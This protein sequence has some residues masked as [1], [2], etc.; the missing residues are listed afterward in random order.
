M[1]FPRL[2]IDAFKVS[3][4][5]RIINDRCTG[6]GISV[7]G[8]TKGVLAHP[9]VTAALM[10]AGIK[11][12]GDSR[13][14][15]VK[16]LFHYTGDPGNIMMLRSPMHDEVE[17][18]INMC[19]TSLN[20]QS[21]TVDMLS[22]ACRKYGKDH[23]IIIMV[24]I[25]DEREGLLPEE[26]YG[27]C[28]YIMG[29]SK[30]IHIKGIGTNARCITSRGP[31]RKSI[32]ILVSLKE[33]LEDRLGL[34]LEIL[35]GG[36]SSIWDMIISGELPP[37]INQVR[38]GEAIF[39]GH[40]TAGYK[41]IEGTFQDCFTLEAEII[42]VKNRDN[43]PYRLVLALG[44]QDVLLKDLRL[45]ERG[46]EAVSQSSDHT[47]LDIIS[48]KGDMEQEKDFSNFRA[49]GIISFNLNYFGLLSCMTSPFVEKVFI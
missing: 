3:H 42:E 22:L 21:A 9:Y 16:R 49:G 30:Y 20:T 7:V 23:N 33:E 11:I 34:Q 26:V 18:V 31:T 4:N 17:E 44:L 39:L 47:M 10:K 43:V 28:R 32:D 41:K 45:T 1:Y 8:V 15:N 25:D 40:E 29:Q 27:F 6:Q 48:Y 12:F 38:I 24:E 46:L 35:S 36:N 37:G 5:A 14:Q 2:K 13:S 19:S